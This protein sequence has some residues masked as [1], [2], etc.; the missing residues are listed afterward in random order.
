M[1]CH[2][3]V[4]VGRRS[5]LPG[6]SAYP[7]PA[8]GS[9]RGAGAGDSLRLRPSKKLVALAALAI[10]ALLMLNMVVEVDQD[11][12]ERAIDRAGILGPIAYTVI[13][14]LGLTIP[15]NP[16]S[17][18]LTVTV[19]S[20]V[21]DP[22]VAI[23][24]TA[25]AQSIAVTVNYYLGARYGTALIDR[26]LERRDIAIVR[27]VRDGITIRA[28]FLLRF[29]LPLTAIGVD[30]IS[31]LA[32]AQRLRFSSYFVAS[33]VPWTTMSVIFF[34]SAA[35]LRETSPFL[36]VLPA[37]GLIVLA[38]L[39]VLLLRRHTHILAPIEDAPVDGEQPE[40]ALPRV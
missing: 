36:V 25:I 8:H 12:L 40:E 9:H 11:D 33:M 15:M 27:R 2:R 39:L 4:S 31:Y 30:W 20:I 19:A 17:D 34:V 18:T 26:M 14:A 16:V 35:Q 7:E 1:Q 37:V 21:L 32:G 6:E 24:A 38:S 3:V 29:A 23:L 10:A 13:L 28:I 5:R 22:K